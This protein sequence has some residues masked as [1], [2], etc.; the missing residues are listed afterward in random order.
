MF[1]PIDVNTN[2]IYN[3]LFQT[4]LRKEQWSAPFVDHLA[5]IFLS[6]NGE[7]KWN[8]SANYCKNKLNLSVRLSQSSCFKLPYESS[9]WSDP[10]VVHP[11]HSLTI[12]KKLAKLKELSELLY[13]QRQF[14][15]SL[16]QSNCFKPLSERSNER[17]FS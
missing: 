14:T 8:G 7:Q 3:W 9:K 2:D 10:F 4:T 1:K 13:V 17:I 16:S 11:V 15:G 5:H 12:I 6:A